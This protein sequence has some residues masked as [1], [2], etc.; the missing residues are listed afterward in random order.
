[1]KIPVIRLEGN[2]MVAE[3]VEIEPIRPM[4][5]VEE[6]YAKA[7]AEFESEIASIDR[8]LAKLDKIDRENS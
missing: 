8:I 5:D 4:D 3:L 6:L 2:R 1:M 7:I